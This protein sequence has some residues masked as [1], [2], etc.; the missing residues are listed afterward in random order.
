[1]LRMG[2]CSSGLDQER[3]ESCVNQ[4]LATLKTA[5]TEKQW[6]A[7]V[8][9]LALHLGWR[10]IYHTWNSMH[11]AKGFPDLVMA[12]ERCVMIECKSETGKL[13]PDQQDWIEALEQAGVEVYVWR[14]SHWD[15][16]V[17]Y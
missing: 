16:A 14:P 7:Q 10:K 3:M 15:E 2:S 5:I 13:K 1:M 11:S 12:R 4:T 8:V 6:Q 9:E 17:R